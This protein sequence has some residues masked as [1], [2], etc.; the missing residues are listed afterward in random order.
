[1]KLNRKQ[2]RELDRNK[3]RLF[4][5]LVCF[6]CGSKNMEIGKGGG[7]Y[8]NDCKEKT[9]AVEEKFYNEMN[10]GYEQESKQNS[11]RCFLYKLYSVSVIFVS[12]NINFTEMTKK[13]N[14]INID[15]VMVKDCFERVIGAY[16][17]E[18]EKEDFLDDVMIT[19]ESLHE[20]YRDRI[21]DEIDFIE[22]KSEGWDV[23]LD[24]MNLLKNM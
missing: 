23:L 18:E 17:K 9:R 2:R 13:T 6:F 19:F 22:N 20:S 3:K 16:V 7:D 4:S 11:K 5:K 14:K 1:M 24:I 15:K 8:C 12:D 10:K 21:R